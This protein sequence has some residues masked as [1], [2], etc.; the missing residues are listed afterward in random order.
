MRSPPPPCCARW[1][2][3]P[4]GEDKGPLSSLFGGG[5]ERSEAEG[6]LAQAATT[7]ITG[8]RT[9]TFFGQPWPLVYLAFTEAWE[10]FSFYGMLSLLTLYMS[11]QLLLPGH[12]E[13]IAGFPAFRSALESIF[14]TMTTLALASQIY[15]IYSASVYFTPL[16]GGWIADRV[17]GRRNA[18]V[19]GA[20]M[21]SAG[22][23][24]MAFDVSFLLA[25]ALLIAGCGLL[26]G[27]ISTQVGALYA[28]D[29]ANGRTRG[30]AIFSTAINVGAVF[31]PVACGA[32]IDR[33]GWHAGFGL[34]GV[35]MI[36]GLVTYLIGYRTL[37]ETPPAQAK[38]QHPELTHDDWRRLYALCAVIAVVVLPAIAFAQPGNMGLVWVHQSVDSNVFGFHIPDPW[39]N[40][41]NA[42]ASIV[43]VPVLIGLWRWQARHGG[44]PAELTKIAI[45]SFICA[46]GNGLL[47][48]G[49]MMGANVTALLPLAAFSTVGVG[50]IYYWPT[51]L[52]LATRVSPERVKA[53]M[54]GVAFLSL[55]A[56]YY[57]LGVLGMFYD[58]MPASEFWSIHAGIGVAGG[59][60]MLMLKRPLEKALAT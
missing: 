12:V 52:G 19:L 34:A 37:P 53:T 21:M 36:L 40:S 49:G 7:D 10:R 58:K 30:F 44:E 29:D 27:N 41:I 18:V 17:L 55:F 8:Q 54:M 26:K 5:A 2:L 47:A 56:S 16:V 22:H 31:G 42:L 50:F 35:L 59:V 38:K 45:G 3:A 13:N 57:L 51:L 46:A 32:L 23:I 25:L 9:R 43:C 33:W 1:T 15:G 6:A 28:D 4:K 11:Q 60:L 24:A 48:L 14:G 39:F 20:A